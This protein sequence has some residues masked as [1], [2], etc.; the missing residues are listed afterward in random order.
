MAEPLK[1]RVDVEVI[2]DLASRASEVWPE[3]DADAF[4][5]SAGVGLEELELKG[6]VA[7]IADALADQLPQD[8]GQAVTIV[9]GMAERGP[10][11]WTAW[12]LCSFVERHGLDHP[13]VSL[14]AMPGLTRHWTCEFA[15]RPYLDRHLELTRDRLRRWARDPDEAVRRLASEGTRPL[16]PWGPRVR[17]LLDDPDIGLELLEELRHDP[18]ETVRRSVANHCND[19]S[20]AHP[21]L[22]VERMRGWRDDGVDPRLLSH[23]LRTLVKQGNPGALDVLGFT[24]DAVIEVTRFDIEPTEVDRGETVTL[25]ADLCSRAEE[26][27]RLVVD[28]VVHHVGVG[29][30]TSPKVFKWT[31]VTMAPGATT[32]LSKRRRIVDGSTRTYHPGEHRVDLQVAGQVVA[33]S[34][35]TL[36][37]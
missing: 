30:A 13:E 1:Q 29:G 19:V 2:A 26:S 35:F 3:F 14:D 5:A 20:K 27:Q 7:Q 4:R 8:Y 9:E 18:S 15:I 28:F 17:A 36:R 37:G 12:P 11:E 33:S 21:E 25:T 10:G 34:A 32:A 16:L 24:V 6:R 31:T 22:I 23:A